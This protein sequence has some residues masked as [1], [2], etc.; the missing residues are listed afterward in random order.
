MLKKYYGTVQ[1]KLHFCGTDAFV[2]AMEKQLL[3]LD[4]LKALECS[5]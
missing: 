4:P 2:L 5:F 3:I 1:N